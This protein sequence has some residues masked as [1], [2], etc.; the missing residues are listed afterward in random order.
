MRPTWHFVTPADIRWMLELTAPRVLSQLAYMDRQVGLDKTTI[1]R[2]HTVLVKALKGGQQ[3]TRLEI[4]S[5][6][7]KSGVQTDGLR[8]THLLM[9]AELDGILCSGGRRGKQFTYA[10]LE[11]RA[12]QAKTREHDEALAELTKRYFQSHGPATLQDFVWWS[13][14]TV[15]EA[16]KGLES[17]QSQLQS[18]VVE[19]Q[20]YWFRASVS[21]E[22][23]S[24][25]VY[26]LPNYDEYTVGYTD[27][28]AIIAEADMDK[29]DPRGGVLV[30]I[31]LGGGQVAGTWKRTLKKNEVQLEFSPFKPLKRREEQAV[32]AAAEQYGQFL[33]LPVVV[34]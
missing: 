31:I 20:T 14:L 33:A 10:L 5:L 25:A 8:F 4:D 29:L 18:E 2:S 16:R 24:P 7:Q 6:L 21:A 13:G 30:Q 17:I 15:A 26:L 27:R 22:K 3:L 9:H 23:A 1:K 32:R 28:R 12:P 34:A 19:N 11:E